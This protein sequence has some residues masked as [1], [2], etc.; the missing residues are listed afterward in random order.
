MNIRRFIAIGTSLVLL[1]L[2][3]LPT[4]SQSPITP[5]GDPDLQGILNHGTITPLERPTNMRGEIY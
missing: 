3:P 5:W 2:F 1:A 4:I